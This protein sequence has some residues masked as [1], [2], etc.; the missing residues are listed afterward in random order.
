MKINKLI[1]FGGII[2]L[3]VATVCLL[4]Y[5]TPGSKFVANKIISRYVEHEDLVYKNLDGNLGNGMEFKNLELKDIK[6]FPEGS[7]LQIQRLFLNLTSL[8]LNGV[9]AEFENIRL[10]LPDSDPIVMSGLF[11]ERQLD[12]NIYSIGFTVTEVLSY[13]PDFKKLIPIKGDV[14]EIDLYVTGSYLEP[15]VKGTLVIDRFVY[16]GFLLSNAPIGV[17]I[18]LKD[19]KDGVKL[20]GSVILEK[21]EL[22]TKKVLVKLEQGD[23]N[24]SGPWN[25]PRIN[26]KGSAKV[27]K[28][29]IS[30]G[31]KGTVEKPELALSSEPSYPRQKLMIMLATGKSWQS[32]EDSIDNGLNSAALTKDFVDY[33]FFAGKSN[34][35]AKRFGIS[36]FSIK[37]DGNNRG[38]AAKKELS[39]KLEVGYGVE[40]SKGSEEQKNITQKLE[41]EY[42]LNEKISVGV[43]RE[44]KQKQSNGLL[45]E[46]VNENND[47]VL[48]KYKK[49]F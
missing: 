36:D 10:K 38:I 16:K 4:V 6:N 27:E 37:L 26:L 21:G 42:K 30:I 43:E 34:Q 44:I 9:Y 1:V 49:S 15:R 45:D 33:F 39:E 23:L 12:I 7:T 19:I 35:F 22:Q 46:Q 47:K 18:Q 3:L 32:V 11:K 28:T 48:L 25:Q 40:Q 2:F 29:K 17:D 14:N 41:G 24:F 5:T 31:L 20:H 13:L 8:S